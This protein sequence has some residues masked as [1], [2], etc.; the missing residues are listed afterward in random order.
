MKLPLQPYTGKVTDVFSD[1]ALV[2]KITV[3][4]AVA[5][6]QDFLVGYFLVVIHLPE[7]GVGYAKSFGIED[8]FVC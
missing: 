6:S 5:G 1:S 7:I 3:T 2:I 8:G 4:K